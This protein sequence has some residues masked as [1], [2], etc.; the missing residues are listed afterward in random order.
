V[1][2]RRFL[3]RSS[4]IQAENR[5]LKFVVIAIGTVTVFNSFMIHKALNYQRVV[6]I[7]PGLES[8]VEVTGDEFSEEYMKTM[9]RYASSLAFTYSPATA[10]KQ[11][12]ALLSLFSVDAYPQ[13]QQTFYELAGTIETANVS[14]V[15]YLDPKLI[16]DAKDKTIEIT[17]QNRK[18]KDSTLVSDT[19]AKYVLEYVVNNGKFQLTKITAK[20][21]ERGK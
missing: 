11:F 13:A 19:V 15:F 16:V 10:R 18:Y 14:S 8:K 21:K 7:P 20:E 3:Q 5:L 4:N 2:I 12:D 6:L 1:N 9:V 17:G